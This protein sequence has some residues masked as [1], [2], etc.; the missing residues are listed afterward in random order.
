M[1]AGRVVN[2]I[3]GL[4]LPR[5]LVQAGSRAV[6]T[7]HDGRFRFTA[8]SETVSSLQITKPGFAL[9]PEQLDGFDLPLAAFP[10]KSAIEALLYPD[11]ILTGVVTASDGTPLPHILITLRR[12]LFNESGHYISPAARTQTDS[13]GNFRAPVPAGDYIVQNEYTRLPYDLDEVILP[14]VLPSASSSDGTGLHVRSGEEV[15]MDLQPALSRTHSVKFAS[16]AN[17]E[18]PPP[19]ISARS[20]NGLTLPQTSG[21]N[22]TSGQMSLDLPN[23]TFVL[24][25]VVPSATGEDVGQSMITVADH[26]LTGIVLHFA[27]VPPVPIEIVAHTSSTSETQN[28]S[29][30]TP[31]P[32]QIALSLRKT[33]ASLDPGTSYDVQPMMLGDRTSVFRAVPGRYRLHA[34]SDSPWYIESATYGASNLLQQE[35]IVGPSVGATPV[36]IVVSN[37]TGSLTGSVKLSNF[38]AACWIYLIATDPSASPISLQH[39][40]T[41]GAF[42]FAHLPPGNYRAFA[43][44]HKHS[45]NFLD[46]DVL[47]AF[48]PHVQAVTIQVG[49]RSSITLDAM[50]T[51][52]LAR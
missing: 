34:S 24:E 37:Q 35:M 43:L 6:L 45:A 25:A 33:Q 21:R 48:A 8:I 30:T 38:P 18:G 26:D 22:H 14:Y 4:P 2:A 17:R 20:A 40:T 3:T 39:S 28:S 44:E 7:D 36:R 16:T 51:R 49:E 9:T 5:A 10:D 29:T 42:T 1:L 41:D 52:E 46:P 15:H 32:Q 47:A 31:T 27:P 19:R 13:Q 12:S 23:G 11:A 50:S